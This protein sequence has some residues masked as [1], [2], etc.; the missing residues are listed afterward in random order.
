LGFGAIEP[1]A[2][3]RAMSF[4]I[5]R[6]E[7]WNLLAICSWVSSPSSTVAKTRSRKSIEYATMP[8]VLACQSN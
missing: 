1:V 3:R 5:H 2:V 8:C 4:R 6:A 7:T